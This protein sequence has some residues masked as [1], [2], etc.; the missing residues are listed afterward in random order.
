MSLRGTRTTD[1]LLNR[2]FR[3]IGTAARVLTGKQMA[4]RNVTVFDDD[5]FIT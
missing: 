4:G 3:V 2:A 5:I 1:S